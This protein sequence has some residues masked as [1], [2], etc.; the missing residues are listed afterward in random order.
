M[1][2]FLP[3]A[4]LFALVSFPAICVAASAGMVLIGAACPVRPLRHGSTANQ[5][6]RNSQ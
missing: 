3:F 2:V 4:V 5:Q 1:T 6:Q